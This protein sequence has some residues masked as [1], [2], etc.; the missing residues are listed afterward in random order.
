MKK[1]LL[2]NTRNTEKGK[3]ESFI[4]SQKPKQQ[5]K[6]VAE[7]YKEIKLQESILKK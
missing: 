6:T 1:N 7:A 4:E 3:L 5:I 2:K